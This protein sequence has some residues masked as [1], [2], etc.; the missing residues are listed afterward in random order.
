MSTSSR[1]QSVIGYLS[2]IQLI[3]FL[4]NYS[5]ELKKINFKKIAF[6][7]ALA[8]IFTFFT[9]KISNRTTELVYPGYVNIYT[10]LISLIIFAPI[11][12][13]IISNYKKS[14][15]PLCL[16]LIIISFVS[17]A[18]VSP[19]NKGLDVMYDKPV[20]KKIRKIMQNNS[21]SKFIAVNSGTVLSNYIVA[22]GGKTLNSTNYL[23]N[24][25]L[26]HSLDSKKKYENVYNRYEHVVVNLVDEKTN[27]ELNYADSITIN[28]NYSDV[29][30]VGVD[31]LVTTSDDT[32]KFDSFKK[33]YGNK[34]VC[35]SF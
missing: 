25:K 4:G 6:L 12:M 34:L 18:F 22:N 24:L 5:F 15:I 20:A 1:V 32:S 14:Y 28:L 11:V 2:I 19:I 8:L 7:V 33:I 31:Y 30:K 26:Y 17:G 16:C 21:N 3:Y 35:K 10:S 29:C 9:I 23:P 13:L 27:F